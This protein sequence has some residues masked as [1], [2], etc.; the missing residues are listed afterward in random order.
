[1]SERQAE[2]CDEA[3]ENEEKQSGKWSTAQTG[4][5]A[6]A[7]RD[8]F[9]DL[10]SLK[11]P[12]AWRTILQNVNKTGGKKS[13]DQAKKKLRNLNPISHGVFFRYFGMGGGRFSPPPSFSLKLQKI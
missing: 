5:H 7:W 11:N 6:N 10:E 13:I 4:A 8:C 12:A 9:V 3:E 2:Q 1:M